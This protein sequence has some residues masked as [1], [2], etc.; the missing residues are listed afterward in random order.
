[1]VHEE[2]TWRIPIGGVDDRLRVLD[3]QGDE[4]PEILLFEKRWTDF[5]SGEAEEGEK[6]DLPSAGRERIARGRLSLVAFSDPSTE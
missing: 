6:R 5:D 2:P 3:V 4:R 1:V